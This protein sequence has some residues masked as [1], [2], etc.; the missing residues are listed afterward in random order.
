M[1]EP[2][3]KPIAVVKTSEGQA[4]TEW[5]ISEACI[6]GPRPSSKIIDFIEKTI[7]EGG[8]LVVREHRWAGNGPWVR[9]RFNPAH[10]VVVRTRKV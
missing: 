3:D 6:P 7:R 2:I 8:E 1:S 10:V 5:D 4:G 9:A